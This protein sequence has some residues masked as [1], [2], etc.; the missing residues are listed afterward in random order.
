MAVLKLW[1][2]TAILLAFALSANALPRKQK[3]LVIHSYHQGLNWTDS[4]TAGIQSVFLNQKNVEI[5]FEYLDTKRNYHPEY[6]KELLKL[7][8]RKLYNIPFKVVVVS[9]DNAFN[10]IREFRDI[11]YPNV[12]IVFCGVNQYNPKLLSGMRNITGVSE[13]VD[14]FRTIELM[15]RLHP[16]LDTVLV[17][18]D[19]CS[20]VTEI[21][22]RQTL[23][24]IA[25]LKTKVRFLFLKD[26][27]LNEMLDKV[28]K[29]KGRKA[30]L[31]NNYTLD[32]AGNY[33]SFDENIQLIRERANVPIYSTW[34]FY[35]GKGI[36]GG[37]LTSG[38]KQGQLA[39]GLV[40]K[41]LQGS[42]ADSLPVVRKGYN[43]YEFDYNQLLRFGISLKQ[44]PP[45]S[46]VINRP[47]SFFERHRVSIYTSI[48]LILLFVVSILVSYLKRKRSERELIRQNDELEW[49]VKQRTIEVQNKNAMLEEQKKQ[50][51]QQ[52]VELEKHRHHLLELVK[53]RT[54]DLE[55][56]HQM[57]QASHKRIINILDASSEG[58]W[59]YKINTG[60]IFFSDKFWEGLGYQLSE[61][62]N[63]IDFVNSLIHPDDLDAVKHSLDVSIH[64]R[65][66]FF[67]KEFRFRSKDGS[68]RWFLSRGKVMERGDDSVRLFVGSH[69]DITQ[70]KQAEQQLLDDESILRASE[71]RWR[72]LYE[73]AAEA[74]IVLNN[75]GEILDCNP[76]A[77][78]LLSLNNGSV[79]RNFISYLP[80][81]ERFVPFNRG[82]DE[83]SSFSDKSENTLF[84]PNGAEIP[85][86]VTISNITIEDS[87]VNM[88]FL[89]DITER[90][91]AE[92]QVLNAVIDTEERE[93]QRF[94]K[95]LHDSIGPLLS[96]LNLYITALSKNGSKERHEQAYALAKETLSET[97]KSIREISNNLGPQ[98]LTDF[99]LKVAIKGFVQR[100]QINESLTIN[101]NLDE[102]GTNRYPAPVEVG[103]YRVVTELINNTLK[104]AAATEVVI[105]AFEQNGLLRL[106]Y[107][108][109]GKGFSF[110]EV[111]GKG[112]HGLSNISS[113]IRS[114][115]GFVRFWSREGKGV[116]V[117]LE[118]PVTSAFSR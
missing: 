88:V 49:H 77:K 59:E 7:Y 5:H 54:D 93:R 13:E 113:R 27:T 63:S 34:N 17:V 66:V 62:D 44:L 3:V 11:Y 58:F 53:E 64:E 68:Y 98:S 87:Q 47:P 73:Q 94:S 45:G 67:K 80:S 115:N 18:D 8:K 6:M 76:S 90:R 24:A 104:H 9:D 72:S 81:I 23:R 109:N 40:L 114:I 51:T 26:V 38:Y 61:I 99:G 2:F 112:G 35:L 30:I 79:N 89:R 41:I 105:N 82:N 65:R 75:N 101:L 55:H 56:A 12:P 10:F 14:F 70:Q 20:I 97:I 50:I 100:L 43:D 32:K 95:D 111:L 102:L 85:V 117:A 84:L 86:E 31:L 118:V 92:R 15:L 106:V 25:S 39:G 37:M 42:K 48:I 110:P 69:T 107:S 57:L 4:I 33:I 21:N 78:T 74:I 29:L 36:V 103:L 116:R 28:T 108:D 83:D 22:R 19:N 71:L 16:L 52:N 91:M 96:A 60:E 1:A 46:N